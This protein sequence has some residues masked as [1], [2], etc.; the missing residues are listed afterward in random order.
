MA[1]AREALAEKLISA[2]PNAREPDLRSEINAI[3]DAAEAHGLTGGAL[4]GQI[5]SWMLQLARRRP[6]WVSAH[7]AF[8]DLRCLLVG[9]ISWWGKIWRG[10]RR[11][12]GFASA[13]WAPF[14]TLVV[15][16]AGAF[17]GL[18]Y[19]RFYARLDVTPD[20]VGLT[21][22]EIVTQ[23]VLGGVV[24][25]L[26]LLLGLFCF[27]LPAVPIKERSGNEKGSWLGVLANT[28][29][30]LLALAALFGLLRIVGIAGDAALRS[31]ILFVTPLYLVA[32]FDLA[33][34]GK[35]PVVR[36]SP[37]DFSLD[38]Y[39]VVLT[40]C[41]VPA[42]VF[43]IFV[44]FALADD[45]GEEASVGKAVRDP[46]IGIF[47]LLGI[48]AEPALVTWK[49]PTNSVSPTSCMLYLGSSDG[50]T[51]LYD[52]R[53]NSTFHIADDELTLQ[54]KGEMSSCEAP[55]NV[56]VPSTLPYGTGELRCEHGGWRSQMDPKYSFEWVRNG[57]PLED[58]GQ[59]KGW[60]LYE[61]AL[62]EDSVVYCRVTATTPLGK[63]VATS[64]P[65]VVGPNKPR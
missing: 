31:V 1:D 57:H 9:P 59:V 28:I 50:K 52:H 15:G 19:A 53:R 45:L 46:K 43:A 7:A 35:R 8:V 33:I 40:A 13:H 17:Y 42:L 21:S 12:A 39:V 11:F 20:Q 56:R 2:Y 36:A 44:T 3:V 65:T 6:E 38:R 25:V 24:L 58:D 47:P 51:T 5:Q 61:E 49:H 37:L 63:D 14:V 10:L 41:A 32:S 48:R 27:L 23:S 54:V 60:L 34:V 64:A 4:D 18:A 62:A 26:L 30:S 29:L 22:T 55:R 16:L